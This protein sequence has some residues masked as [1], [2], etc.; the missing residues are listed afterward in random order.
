MDSATVPYVPRARHATPENWA[1]IHRRWEIDVLEEVR[2]ILR[3]APGGSR[4]PEAHEAGGG[5]GGAGVDLRARGGAPMAARSARSREARIGD[6]PGAAP[7][8]R[9]VVHAANAS[10]VGQRVGAAKARRRRAPA[11]KCVGEGR[12][13]RGD[14]VRRGRHREMSGVT[15]SASDSAL[16][17]PLPHYALCS[18]LSLALIGWGD[19]GLSLRVSVFPSPFMTKP[20]PALCTCFNPYTETHRRRELSQPRSINELT[21]GTEMGR[22]Q[23]KKMEDTALNS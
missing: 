1:L 11:R 3:R 4:V 19:L 6:V 16:V 20:D 23:L 5:F 17:L 9:E 18:W 2:A 12:R 10:A 15:V 7:T 21:I 8:V 14:D 13:F 22:P